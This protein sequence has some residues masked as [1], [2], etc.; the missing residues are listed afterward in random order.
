VVQQDYRTNSRIRIRAYRDTDGPDV[1]ALFIK[2]N[3]LLAPL[4]LT[5]EFDTYIETSINQEIGRISEYYAEK[6]GRFWVVLAANHVAGIFGLEPSRSG[7]MEL[8]R[9]YVDP[10]HR[11]H[12]IAT[13]MLQYAEDYCRSHNIY[14][15]DLSTSELQPDALSFYRHSEYRLVREVIAETTNNKTIGAGIRRFHFSKNLAQ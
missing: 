14:R 8:R 2:I 3:K 5:E 7:A 13:K 6:G 15:I 11:R 1:I 9:M 10:N 12:G 4:H